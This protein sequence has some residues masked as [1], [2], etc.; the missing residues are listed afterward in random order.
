MGRLPRIRRPI[1]TLM[2]MATMKKQS[3]LTPIKQSSKNHPLVSGGTRI[4][5]GIKVNGLG[6]A[7]M[8]TLMLMATIKR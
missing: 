6:G 2:L 4:D 5:E 8:T 1:P 3:V 7:V